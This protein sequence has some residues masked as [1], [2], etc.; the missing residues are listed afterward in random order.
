MADSLRGQLASSL[1]KL[2]EVPDSDPERWSLHAIE[3]GVKLEAAYQDLPDELAS[4]G[5]DPLHEIRHFLADRDIRARDQEY[6][7]WQRNL[8]RELIAILEAKSES[9]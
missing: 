2:L 9:R 1:R 4:K 3:V 5:G 7:T 8:I 6:A